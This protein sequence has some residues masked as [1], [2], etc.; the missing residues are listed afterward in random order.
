MVSKRENM[1]K[2]VNYKVVVFSNIISHTA[3]MNVVHNEVRKVG[4][5]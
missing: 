2:D 5:L 1:K 4:A 3:S